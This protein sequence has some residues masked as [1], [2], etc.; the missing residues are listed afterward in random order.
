MCIRDR[1]TGDYVIYETRE[2]EIQYT[3]P[4][5]GYHDIYL[6]LNAGLNVASFELTGFNQM[7]FAE[8]EAAVYEGESVDVT[9]R[10]EN[11]KSG[12]TASVLSLIHIYLSDKSEERGQT[13]S[14]MEDD[15]NGK[16]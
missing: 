2:Y 8:S 4:L 15:R 6:C 14:I 5:S 9:V 16:V 1:P 11:P 10:R 12:E 13:E 3:E 7:S